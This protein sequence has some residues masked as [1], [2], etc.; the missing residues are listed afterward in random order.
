MILI[1][2]HVFGQIP[3][4]NAVVFFN[5]TPAIVGFYAMASTVLDYENDT[6]TTPLSR[7]PIQFIFNICA[8]NA[9]CTL[10]PI[11]ISDAP[12]D[13]CIFIKLGELL[14]ILIR[15]KVQCPNTTLA[16]VIEVYP[17]GFTQS[18]FTVYYISSVNQGV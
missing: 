6:S 2:I 5:L 7:V 12:A 18:I 13:Q 17:T 9:T 4:K 14:T 10:P 15:I 16:N 1:T 11:Y 8:S 3:F